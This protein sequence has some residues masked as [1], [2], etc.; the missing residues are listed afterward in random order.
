MEQQKLSSTFDYYINKVEAKDV[1]DLLQK[2][3]TKIIKIASNL[4]SI[5]WQYSYEN[6]KWSIGQ[7]LYH[8]L[9][10]ERIM[11]YRALTFARGE[12]IELPGYNHESYAKEI[13]LSFSTAD[14]FVQEYELLRRGTILLFQGFTTQQLDRIAHFSN[15]KIAVRQLQRLIAGHESHHLEILCKR[16]L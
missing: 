5:K 8:L 15:Q 9:D 14:L 1:G 4:D 3:A 13:D 2:N 11:S 10:T 12:Q 6:D 7:L 16:Y